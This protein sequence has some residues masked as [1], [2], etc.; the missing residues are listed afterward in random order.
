MW[1]VICHQHLKMDWAA[2]IV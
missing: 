2:R 1:Q